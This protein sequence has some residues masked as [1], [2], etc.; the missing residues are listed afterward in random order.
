MTRSLL[1]FYSRYRTKEPMMG[2]SSIV[3]SLGFWNSKLF[4]GVRL[5]LEFLPEALDADFFNALAW[6]I[7]SGSDLIWPRR[8]LSSLLIQASWYSCTHL[9]SGEKHNYHWL[10]CKQNHHSLYSKQ[11]YH[12]RWNKIISQG[13][14]N[15]SITLCLPNKIITYCTKNYLSKDS[16]QN[17]HSMK[18]RWNHHFL[19]SRKKSFHGE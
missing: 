1:L 7:L 14:A 2:V 8:K 5:H 17:Y 4:C 9:I 15:K 12:S 11:N 19:K 16:K 6:H 3:Q 18:S 13:R 10:V